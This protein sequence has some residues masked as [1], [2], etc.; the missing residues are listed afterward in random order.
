MIS[1][2]NTT[3]FVCDDSESDILRLALYEHSIHSEME[4]LNRLFSTTNQ[5]KIR[6]TIARS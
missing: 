6:V 3:V 5:K 4:L 2:V 1:G